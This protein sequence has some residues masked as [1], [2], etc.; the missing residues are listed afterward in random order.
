MEETICMSRIKIRRTHLLSRS[1]SSNIF[2]SLLTVALLAVVFIFG[3]GVITYLAVRGRTVA[4]PNVVGKSKEAAREELDE[5][6]LRMH[7]KS[8]APND[9]APAGSVTD[10]SPSAGTIVKTG[11]IVRVGISRGAAPAGQNAQ[12]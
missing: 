5:A 12:K 9:K 10:Q 7:V 11:Q 3:A 8:E 1:G 2:K 6:G 4:V